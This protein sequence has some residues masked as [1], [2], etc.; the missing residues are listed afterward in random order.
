MKLGCVITFMVCLA[1]HPTCEAKERGKSDIVRENTPL[2]RRSKKLAPPNP[3]DVTNKETTPK[4]TFSKMFRQRKEGW[5]KEM[6]QLMRKNSLAIKKIDNAIVKVSNDL[7][8]DP[9]EKNYHK[10]RFNIMKQ[11]LNETEE[12]IL[13]S[14]DWLRETLNDD[15]NDIMNMKE[16]AKKRL[17]KLRDATL[18]EE[19]EYNSLIKAE[20][21]Y[22]SI[23]HVFCHK[24]VEKV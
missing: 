8:M 5:C 11:E 10:I 16:G 3:K 22:L 24:I 20:V 15:Y 12:V 2:L 4:P 6:N 14:F 21:K 23:F 17:E 13:N 7:N 18:R 9:D 1:G 19:Q